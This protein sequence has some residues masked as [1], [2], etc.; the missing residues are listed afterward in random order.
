MKPAVAALAL[1]ACVL[2][3]P[4]LVATAFLYVMLLSYELWLVQHLPG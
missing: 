3:G 2:A 1:A 4:V